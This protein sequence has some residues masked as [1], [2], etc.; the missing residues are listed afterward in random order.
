[1]HQAVGN[2]L[3]VLRQRTPPNHLDDAH[4]LVDLH[5]PMLC[6]LHVPLFYSG[7]TTTPGALFALS[8]CCCA[9]KKYNRLRPCGRSLRPITT[10]YDQLRP[11]RPLPPITT[12]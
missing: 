7:L 3:R 1:M 5:W 4:L 9:A 12:N 8:L 6:M 2:S 11:L 10:N